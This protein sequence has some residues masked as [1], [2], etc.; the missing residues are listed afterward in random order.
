MLI[1]N[2][3]GKTSAMLI[4]RSS[5]EI[6]NGLREYAKIPL[7]ISFP[8]FF[9]WR[10]KRSEWLNAAR[11]RCS[12]TIEI[13][14]M[15]TPGK[16]IKILLWMGFSKKLGSSD[17]ERWKVWIIISPKKRRKNNNSR[18]FCRMDLKSVLFFET[19]I[20]FFFNFR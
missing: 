1:K 15:I 10:P 17:M 4:N 6:K 12:I 14:R 2:G 8:K 20:P 3:V 18:I 19:E 7:V 13:I 16:A 9:E 5:I 11:V